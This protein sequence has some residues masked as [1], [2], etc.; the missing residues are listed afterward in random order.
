MNKEFTTLFMF[1][2]IFQE[3]EIKLKPVVAFDCG[4][5][6]YLQNLV[7][8]LLFTKLLMV[9]NFSFLVKMV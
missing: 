7:F 8:G 6:S 2:H 4:K 1:L 3:E 9:F 5:A